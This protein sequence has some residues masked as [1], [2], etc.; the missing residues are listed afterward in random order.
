M[1]KIIF[2]TKFKENNIEAQSSIFVIMS[3]TDL[4][5]VD[6]VFQ[7][8]LINILS[9]FRSYIGLIFCLANGITFPFKVFTDDSN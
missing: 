8:I 4:E 2:K 3:F 7:L 5:V 1:K 6:L 9:P